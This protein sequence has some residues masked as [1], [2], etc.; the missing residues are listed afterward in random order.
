MLGKGKQY[1]RW[2][3]RDGSAWT[4][5]EVDIKLAMAKYINIYHV[6]I[7]YVLYI[8]THNGNNHHNGNP[9]KLLLKISL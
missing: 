3:E 4:E 8:K 9:K 6:L 2:R 1:V 7:Q 5:R